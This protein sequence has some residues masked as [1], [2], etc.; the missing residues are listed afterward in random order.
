MHAATKKQ[1]APRTVL[2]VD[3]SAVIRAQVR[4]LFLA[5]GFTLCS[6]AENGREAIEMACDCNPD[7]IILDLAMPLMSGIEAA[8]KLRE[9]LPGIPILL[10]TLHADYLKTI[11]LASLG[12]TAALSK[13]DPLENLLHK[14]RELID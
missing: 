14:A 11:D 7:I 6:E 1:P 10:F 2:V 9:L 12:I 3:D 8:P 13:N 4:Q 5:D